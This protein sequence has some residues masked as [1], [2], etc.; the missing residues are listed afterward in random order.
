MER[1]GAADILRCEEMESNGVSSSSLVFFYIF[2][3]MIWALFGY[4]GG[5]VAQRKGYS[6]GLGFAV[7]FFGGLIGIIVLYLIKPARL[8]S[9][10]EMRY[11]DQRYYRP[12]PED[13]ESGNDPEP[14]PR[15]PPP[16]NKVCQ[17]C[18]NLVPG[19]AQFCSYCGA[20]V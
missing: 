9:D 12:P 13:R 14:G 7:G 2:A 15:Q 6:F 3:V 8:P 5:K 10:H 11:P 17:Q 18:R 1:A 16:R 20:R 19:D 4:W